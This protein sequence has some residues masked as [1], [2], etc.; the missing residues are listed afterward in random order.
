MKLLIWI[1]AIWAIGLIPSALEAA[2]D[3]ISAMKKDANDK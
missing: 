1:V 3:Y 2:L